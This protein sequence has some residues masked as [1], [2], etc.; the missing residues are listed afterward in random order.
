MAIPEMSVRPIDT[1]VKG[2]VD[3]GSLSCQ[4]AVE[5]RSVPTLIGSMNRDRSWPYVASRP[6]KRGL[7]SA[8]TPWAPRGSGIETND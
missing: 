5:T 7:Q 1:H 6:L 8:R 4:N 2:L 3:K